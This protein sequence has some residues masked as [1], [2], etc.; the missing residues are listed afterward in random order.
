MSALKKR[1]IALGCFMLVAS[2]IYLLMSYNLPKHH[3]GLVTASFVP[4]VLGI[5]M[6]G[7]GIMQL[8]NARKIPDATSGG[9]SAE[10]EEV[11]YPT[12]GKTVALIVGFA[13]LMPII[14]FPIMAVVY[15]FLQFIVLTP[16]KD[17][18]NYLLY[19]IISLIASTVI[20]LTFRHVFDL[21]LPTGLL[22]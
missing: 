22:G 5:I 2:A 4:Y 6:F 11:D 13:A 10:K 9:K 1:E 12:V 3:I 21:M 18:P 20:Y 7:L 19:G 14:G 15:L 17:K 8:R 16:G